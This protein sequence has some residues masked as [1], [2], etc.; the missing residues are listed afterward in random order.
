[1]TETGGFTNLMQRIRRRDEEAAVEL[2]RL[3]EPVIRLEVRLRLR[4]R[5]LRRL[6]DSSDVCQSAL[7][8]F[9]TRAAAGQ[10][11]L[12]Q[13]HDLLKLLVVIARRKLALQVRQLLCPTRNPGPQQEAGEEEREAVDPASGPAQLASDHELLRE[14]TA[15][16]SL[17]EKRLAE[18]RADGRSWPEIAA[19]LGGEPQA[20]RK[21]LTRAAARVLQELGLNEDTHV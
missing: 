5:R 15:R 8:T 16:L 20:R 17:E 9:F 2:F 10:Y 6:F 12:D 14:F 1:M 18:L 3:Y 7:A 11:V 21:Q 4:D 19:E 13:P